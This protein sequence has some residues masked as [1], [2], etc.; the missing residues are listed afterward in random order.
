MLEEESIIEGFS[1]YNTPNKIPIDLGGDLSVD[2]IDRNKDV[3]LG[4]EQAEKLLKKKNK[5][6]QAVFN[7][8][9]QLFEESGEFSGVGFFVDNE[10]E[11]SSVQKIEAM[12][13]VDEHLFCEDIFRKI[14]KICF[15]DIDDGEEISRHIMVRVLGGESINQRLE[16]KREFVYDKRDE[17]AEK[18]LQNLE[19]VYNLEGLRKRKAMLDEK[20]SKNLNSVESFGYSDGDTRDD[21]FNSDVPP[22][23]H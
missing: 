1:T 18:F 21:N 14:Y 13:Q 9:K 16:S 23:A 12:S 6:R 5:L 19:G 3:I 22:T 11:L 4:A 20:C 7:N 2:K 15:G 10:E 17:R 8:V